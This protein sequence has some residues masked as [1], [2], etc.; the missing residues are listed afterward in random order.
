MEFQGFSE[1]SEDFSW[2]FGT[3][4]FSRPLNRKWGQEKGDFNTLWISLAFV[5]ETD[6]YFLHHISSRASIH[7]KTNLTLDNFSKVKLKIKIDDS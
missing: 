2:I 5:E 6:K 7:S 3:I 1:F 4:E